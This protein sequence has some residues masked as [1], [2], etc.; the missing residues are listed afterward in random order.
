MDYCPKDIYF[1]DKIEKTRQLINRLFWIMEIENEQWNKNELSHTLNGLT[2]QEYKE[3]ERELNL[4][5][6]SR[7]VL[8]GR[9]V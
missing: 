9:K 3:F 8:K 4:E 5:I 2:E 1:I 6:I 7:A